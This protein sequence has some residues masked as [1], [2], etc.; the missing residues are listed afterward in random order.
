MT[1]SS[2]NLGRVR[3]HDQSIPFFWKR[4]DG[5]HDHVKPSSGKRKS[6]WQWS[7][8]S[9]FLEKDTLMVTP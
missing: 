6:W 4:G 7:H 5:D 2:P 9:L 1:M 3:G 8:H